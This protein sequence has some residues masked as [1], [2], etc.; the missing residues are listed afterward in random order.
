MHHDQRVAHHAAEPG[1]QVEVVA[2]LAAQRLA[3]D[4]PLDDLAGPRLGVVEG[5]VGH[6]VAG[7]RAHR[8]RAE[9]PV[10]QLGVERVVEERLGVVVAGD[11]EA[12]TRS[13]SPRGCRSMTYQ[14]S[15]SLHVRAAA[16]G[17]AGRP[18]GAGPTPR[19]RARATGTSPGE[20]SMIGRTVPLDEPVDRGA[21]E[22]LAVEQPVDRQLGRGTAHDGGRPP[23]S[24]STRASS[25]TDPSAP[26]STWVP[27]SSSRQTAGANRRTNTLACTASS[28]RSRRRACGIATTSRTRPVAA[29]PDLGALHALRP[30]VV[31]EHHALGHRHRAGRP[32]DDGQLGPRADGEQAQ[33]AQQDADVAAGDRPARRR[34]GAARRPRAGAGRSARCPRA[35]R[36]P[37]ARR[38]AGRRS[39]GTSRRCRA[40][41]GRRRRRPRRRRPWRAG[42]RA[43]A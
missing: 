24:V 38:T 25:G 23:V 8:A 43:T 36:P 14:R 31:V 26:I 3:G 16:A 34:R 4:A 29:V 28:R 21:V 41:P 22:G 35:G 15:V 7:R 12:G 2:H 42:R 17:R 37:P 40:P 20:P 19:R 33:A 39:A 9:R 11:L 30:A 10:R 5:P 13:A 6:L 32:G 18:P 1:R 27:S